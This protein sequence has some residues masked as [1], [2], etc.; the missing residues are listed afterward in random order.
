MSDLFC[1]PCAMGITCPKHDPVER[2]RGTPPTGMPLTKHQIIAK[3]LNDAATYVDT[4]GHCK[5]AYVTL[6]GRVCSLGAII[7]TLDP[8]AQ[9]VSQLKSDEYRLYNDCK[10]RLHR[11][12]FPWASFRSFES[13]RPLIVIWNDAPE[14]T[15][16]HV[17]EAL[18]KASVLALPIVG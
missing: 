17:S 6:D 15:A 12:I 7:C 1:E 9:S 8:Q 5:G 14:R 3:T 13:I 2:D 10:E 18:R 4:H 16:A 11:A